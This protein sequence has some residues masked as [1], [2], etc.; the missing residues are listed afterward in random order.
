MPDLDWDRYVTEYHDAN[1]GITED[2]LADARDDG[3]RSPYDWLVEGLPAGAATVVDVGCGSGPVAGMLPGIRVVGV[4]R[5]AGELARARADGRLRLLCR[6]E[7]TA[8]PVA[9]G[10]ADAAVASMTLMIL[11]PLEAVLAEVARV[12]RPGGT[13]VAT[14]PVRAATPGPAGT[15]AFA[16]ILGALGQVGAQ[17]PEPLVGPDLRRRFAAAGLS[18]DRY[19]SA[20]FARTV[21]GPDDAARVVRSFYAPG[22]GPDRL[23]AA[24]EELQRRVRSAPVAL[25]YRIR[26][27]VAHR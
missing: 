7:A 26:R 20:M 13:L 21:R 14:V 8:L 3:G 1:P 18:L 24:T 11:A 12:L 15:P 27:L 5:S 23:A 25:T 16:D 17:Y 4:D 6:A 2:V 22:A 9:G 10:C 19:D